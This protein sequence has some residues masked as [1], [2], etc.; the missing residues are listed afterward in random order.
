MHF[1][2]HTMIQVAQLRQRPRELVDSK[3]S[4]TRVSLTLN[5]R[6]NANIYGPLDGYNTT[7]PLEVFTQR[8]FCSRLYLIEIDFI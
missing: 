2:S 7:L 3:G 1:Y 5:F 8:N 4:V 6:L